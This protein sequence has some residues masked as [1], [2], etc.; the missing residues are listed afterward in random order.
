MLITGITGF[1][2]RWT[3]KPLAARGFEVHGLSSKRPSMAIDCGA[4]VHH[5][6]IHDREKLEA[7]IA[8][9]RPTH[10]LHLAW[11][12]TPGVYW[13]TPENF[14]WVGASLNLMRAAARHG[15]RRIVM[16]GSCAEYDW[17]AGLCSEEKT[18][19]RPAT[20]YGSCKHALAQMV[21]AFGKQERI[22]TAWGRI[23]FLF[24]PHEHPERLVPSVIR[25]IMKAQPAECT[26]G[27]Q[28]RDFLY[29]A[30]VAGAFAALL[31][32]SAEGP[33]NI[34]SGEPIQLKD[35]VTRIGA[36]MGRADLLRLG[37]RPAPRDEPL[38][39]IPDVTRLR[40]EIGWM[41]SET[42]DGGLEKTID[43][44]RSVDTVVADS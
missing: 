44:W 6:D 8:E 28:V 34:G 33:V 21:D 27:N 24:G 26:H 5:V 39:L 23:F 42:L 22:S 4:L 41:P 40:E 31:D 11:V 3:G 35:L 25:A 14:D 19:L 10:L 12:T 9:V 43:W 38:E 30:D 13:E 20:V 32:S 7:V 16:A 37:T 18:P 17:S 36:Q 15:C 1:I 2:G 29:S